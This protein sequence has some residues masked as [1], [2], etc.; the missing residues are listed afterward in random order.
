MVQSDWLSVHLQPKLKSSP[1]SCHQNHTN[2]SSSSRKSSNEPNNLGCPSIRLLLPRNMFYL[3]RNSASG[4]PRSSPTRCP[5]LF[6][7]TSSSSTTTATSSTK[8]TNG[9]DGYDD[10]KKPLNSSVQLKKPSSKKTQYNLIWINK[11]KFDLA[12]QSNSVEMKPQGQAKH[13]ADWTRQLLAIGGIDAPVVYKGEMKEVEAL[14]KNKHS[15]ST[16][17]SLL[18][19]STH[20]MQFFT[21]YSSTPAGLISLDTEDSF[22]R[23]DR[24]TTLTVPSSLGLTPASKVCSPNSKL[25]GFI[26]NIPVLPIKTSK[27][28]H[29]MI[30]KLQEQRLILEITLE[31]IFKELE[32]RVLS[33]EEMRKCFNWWINMTSLQGYNRLVVLRFLHCAVLKYEAP[34]QPHSGV[35]APGS[36]PDVLMPLST[37]LSFINIKSV[38]TNVHLPLHCLPFCL[39]KSMS[40]E[41]LRNVFGF[42]ELSILD[43]T[44]KLFSSDLK[45]LDNTTQSP[46]LAKKLLNI[47]PIS[48]TA[49]T[50]KQQAEILSL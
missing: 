39:T 7:M 25:A 19:R 29:A 34:H 17:S 16:Q 38:P 3:F 4:I 14:L 43:F 41:A 49:I 10:S 6:L 47:L 11:D 45:G 21:F 33:F 18:S 30:G 40:S 15:D 20:A 35:P 24:N 42:K 2:N 44:K 46:L 26:K 9:T 50:N 32:N 1:S 13:L 22:F 5:R 36:S 23:C 28:A 12:N 37:A 31:D 48:W 8:S 27:E